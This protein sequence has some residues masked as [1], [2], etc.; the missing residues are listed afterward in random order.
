MSNVLL[1]VLLTS[2]LGVAL[3]GLGLLAYARKRRFVRTA[4]R[5]SGVV[6]AL[7]P[8]ISMEESQPSQTVYAPSVEF[9]T[10]AGEPREFTSRSASSRPA[11]RIGQDVAVIYDPRHPGK[12]VILTFGE[13]WLVPLILWGIGALFVLTAILVAFGT[14]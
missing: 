5:T 13:V 14:R 11:Y 9:T 2:G 7:V 12:A 4:A 8:R 10:Q 1:A 3:I 6:T